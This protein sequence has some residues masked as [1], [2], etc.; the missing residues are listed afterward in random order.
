MLDIIETR[1]IGTFELNDKV[2]VTD[3]GYNKDTWCRTTLECKPGIYSGYAEISDEGEF[4]KRVARLS[5][6]KDDVRVPLK[7]M[8]FIDGNIGVDAGLCGFFNNKPDFDDFDEWMNFLQTSGCVDDW[9]AKPMKRVYSVDYGIFSESGYG[10]GCYIVYA[11][12][13]RTA[14]TLV[15]INDCDDEE[16]DDE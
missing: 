1:Y 11:N 16:E 3:P 5:I 9:D 4:G 7:E 15:F 12:A 8:D 13:D 14:F 2:D 10:D 6:Y